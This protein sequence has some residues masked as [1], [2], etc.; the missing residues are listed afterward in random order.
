M[1]Y[2][3]AAKDDAQEFIEEFS[4]QI[5]LQMIEGRHVSDDFRNDWD[6]GDSYFHESYV[7]REYDLSEAAELLDQLDDFEETDSGLWEGQRRRK[8]E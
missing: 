7:D 1:D 3:K 2:R 4:E 8:V 6:R 5:Q